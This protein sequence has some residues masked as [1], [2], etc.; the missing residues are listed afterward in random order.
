M[1]ILSDANPIEVFSKASQILADSCEHTLGPKG[2]NTAV[3]NSKGGY[4]IINDG[5]SII[6]NLTSLDED[7]Y[8][9][10][11][12]L[13]QAS[14]ETNRKAGDGTTSTIVMTNALMQACKEYLNKFPEVPPTELRNRLEEARDLML[15]AL[16]DLTIQIKDEDY[17]KIATVA[18]GG[19]KYS[20]M[21]ADVFRFLDKGQRP[22]LLK[23]ND[24]NIV[25]EKID[26]MN[27]DKIKVPGN[28]FIETKEFPE[29]Q[30]LCLYQE[31]NRF[32]E[33]TQLLKLCMKSDKPVLLL[34]NNLSVDILENLL[35]NYNNRSY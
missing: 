4:D 31:L 5:K 16:D 29:I 3:L 12:T 8:P 18:L 15:E 11:E 20:K 14:F 27:L 28:L 10:L 21:I 26:G 23:S 7:I 25:V 30:V 19:D 17:E 1:K 33:I 2:T 32:P 24:E 34:Y 6:E 9:A 13:K 35:F 22:T